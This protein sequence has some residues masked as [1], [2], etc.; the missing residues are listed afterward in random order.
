MR[1]GL[2]PVFIY[3]CL[4]SSRRW[5]GYALRSIGLAALL[6]AM[7]TIAWS[8]ITPM[9]GDVRR[10]YARLGEAYF[11][12][13][14]GVELVIVILAAPAGTAGAICFDRARGTLAHMLMTDLSDAEIVL[15]RLGARLMPV[16]G[17]V[18]C[19]W[20]VMAISTLLGGIDPIAV[21]WAFAVIVSV[22]ILGCTLALTLSVWVKKAHQ[23][24]L[25]TYAIFLGALL[26]WP[27]WRSLSD[28]GV[29]G[30]PPDWPLRREPSTSGGT[31]LTSAGA[32]IP[33][34]S[35]EFLRTFAT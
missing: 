32:Y 21:T 2:G 16:M 4:T 35:P 19:S 12:G 29:C 22:A 25:V 11:H 5:Q 3:E 20:P 1:W 18:A 23:V 33:G 14:I 26:V 10:D 15:G 8:R 6:F 27:I 30:L 17:L 24:I 9:T 34:K 13:L 28:S 7:G 31:A